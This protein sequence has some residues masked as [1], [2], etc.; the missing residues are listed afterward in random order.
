MKDWESMNRRIGAAPRAIEIHVA[1][2][3]SIVWSVGLIMEISQRWFP[4]QG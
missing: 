2:R 4:Y 1:P 3:A